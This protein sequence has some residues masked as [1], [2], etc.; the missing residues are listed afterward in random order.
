MTDLRAILELAR[1]QC[2]ADEWDADQIDGRTA[3]F[4][5]KDGSGLSRSS[6]GMIVRFL[7]RSA[8][9][10]GGDPAPK[11]FFFAHADR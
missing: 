7:P 1:Q 5:K 9:A 10:Q 2:I 4:F 8:T 3:F 11:S 6:S